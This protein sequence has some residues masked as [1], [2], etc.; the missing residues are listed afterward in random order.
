MKPQRDDNGSL[1]AY[2]WPGGYP[3]F[4]LC[5]DSGILCPTCANKE[6][7][8]AEADSH[9]DYPDYDQWRIVDADVN[10]EDSSLYCDNCSE[11]IE[12]AYAEPEGGGE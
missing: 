4:Y 11:R 1:P 3:I 12:S 9:A 8:V 5:A 7:A 2:V 6:S 10:W